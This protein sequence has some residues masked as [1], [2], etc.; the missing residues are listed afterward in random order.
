MLMSTLI[1]YLSHETSAD[2]LG[3]LFIK[4]FK[5]LKNPIPIKLEFPF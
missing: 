5:R 1:P 3:L 2:R 4:I